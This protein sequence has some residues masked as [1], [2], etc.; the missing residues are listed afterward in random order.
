VLHLRKPSLIPYLYFIR[1][2]CIR[3]NFK[4][5]DRPLKL[6]PQRQFHLKRHIPTGLFPGALAIWPDHADSEAASVSKTTTLNILT[7]ITL[8]AIAVY[9][10]HILK[11]REATY[12]SPVSN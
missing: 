3:P 9:I 12:V 7:D 10:P 8:L 4:L 5:Q 6:W 2:S 1:Y 11:N